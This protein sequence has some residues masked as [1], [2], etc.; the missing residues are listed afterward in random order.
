[1]HVPKSVWAVADAVSVCL[2]NYIGY[3]FFRLQ[4]PTSTWVAD[5]TLANAVIAVAYIASGLAVGL[6]ETETLRHRSRIA[7]RSLLTIGLATA[8]AYVVLHTLMYEIYSRR[9][10]II[11]PL[12]FIAVSGG[13]RLLACRVLR[14]LKSRILFVGCG[15]SVR[16]I[17]EAVAES[18]AGRNYELLG[19]LAGSGSEPNSNALG[20]SDLARLGNV[21][22]IQAVCL[23]EDVQEVVIGAEESSDAELSQLIMCCLRLGCR[24]TN[25]PTFHERVLGEVPVDHIS[26]DWFLF[27]DLEGH[28]AGRATIKRVFDFS[29]SALTLLITLPLWPLIALAVKVS[30]SG[31]VFYSQERVGRHNRIFR[32]IKFRTMHPDAE[33]DGHVWSTPGDPRVTR[34]GRFL[35][36]THLDELPQLWNIFLGDMSLVGPRPERPEFVQE[37]IAEIP[38]YDERHLVKPGLTGWAQ[39]N[40]RYGC[41][42]EDARRKLFLDLYYIKQMSLE[43]DLVI[44]FRTLG[45]LIRHPI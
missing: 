39:I 10:A 9:I 7:V 41:T 42:V 40:Y 22:D 43:L 37:L 24:V 20:A 29:F 1:M 34:V 36:R 27:A 33:A 44:I 21:E 45:I 25:P 8:I 6:Y 13:L 5:M 12:T 17:S 2:G 23:A 3:Q 15:D 38:Y 4:F 30:G 28:R 11:S 18:E 31:P 35:R 16:R 19:Y 26:A 14:N 32:L